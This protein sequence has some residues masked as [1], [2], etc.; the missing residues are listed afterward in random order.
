MPGTYNTLRAIRKARLL[1]PAVC[2][3][4]IGAYLFLQKLESRMRIVSNQSTSE[5]VRDPAR[6]RG[7]ARRVGYQDDAVPVGQQLLQAYE[8]SSRSVRQLFL[9][10]LGV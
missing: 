7:L 10:V 3:T 4:L 5:L 2:G 1:E 6:L 9:E 8:A